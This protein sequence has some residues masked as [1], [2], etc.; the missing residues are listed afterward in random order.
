MTRLA[1]GAGNVSFAATTYACGRRWAR[2]AI[3]MSIVA[4]SVQ[5][6]IDGKVHPGP[7]HPPRPLQRAQRV[8]QPQMTPRRENSA[9]GNIA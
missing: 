5:L 3:D 6:G 4:G 7:P 2:T 9:A 8:R 1:D